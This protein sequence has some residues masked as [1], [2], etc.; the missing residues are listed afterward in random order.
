MI[1]LSSSLFKLKTKLNPFWSFQ[2]CNNFSSK[3][4]SSET[5][6]VIIGIIRA[7]C[8]K[9][10]KFHT[11]FHKKFHLYRWWYYWTSYIIFFVSKGN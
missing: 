1:R 7:V 4:I 9:S 10:N 8:D 6:V 3:T 5:D 11:E 2:L